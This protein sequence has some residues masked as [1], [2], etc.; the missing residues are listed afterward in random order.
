MKR[1]TYKDSARKAP[2]LPVE[3]QDS[4]VSSHSC[5]LY[6]APS[7]LLHR[8]SGLRIQQQRPHQ[9]ER[10]VQRQVGV[11]AEAAEGH[12]QT[13][14]AMVMHSNW[15]ARRPI[16]HQMSLRM[17]YYERNLPTLEFHDSPVV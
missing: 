14:P 10:Q 9:F 13:L 17:R 11:V 16:A 4:Y 2:Y 7:S 6:E 3:E 8:D 5:P 15:Q 1:S 12:L